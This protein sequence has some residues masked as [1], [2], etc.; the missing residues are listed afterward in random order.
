MFGPGAKITRVNLKPLLPER[1]LDLLSPELALD[2]LRK[3]IAKS[4]RMKIRQSALSPQAKTRVAKGFK[5][6]VGDSSITLVA[7][8]PAFRPLIEGR[9]RRQMRWL[10]KARSPIPIILDDG[11]VIFRSATPRSME[12]GSWYHPGRESTG[13]IESAKEEAKEML[14]KSV[15]R[16]LQEQLRAAIRR[17]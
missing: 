9:R 6:V 5:V 16:H 10:T 3:Q 14:R 13:I 2:Q 7:T 4:I 17:R 12:N 8:D 1:A 15:K 11:E